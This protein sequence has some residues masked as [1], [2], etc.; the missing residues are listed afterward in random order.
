MTGSIFV[1]IDDHEVHNLRAFMNEIFGEE[2][3]VASMVWQRRTARTTE[4]ASRRSRLHPHVRAK[5]QSGSSAKPVPS[6]G[7]KSGQTD[8]LRNLGRRPSGGLALE[9]R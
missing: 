8:A 2:N 7:S 4:A 3:F 1:S 9:A 6:D 5:V